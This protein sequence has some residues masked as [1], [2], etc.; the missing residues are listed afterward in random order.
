MKTINQQLDKL[1]T[2]WRLRYKDSK[3]LEKFVADGLVYKY[4]PTW[5]IPKEKENIP[6]SDVDLWVEKL[7][8]DSPVRVAFILKDKNTPDGDDVRQWL[9]L[10]NENGE[11]NRNLN[12]RIMKMLAA[13]LYGLTIDKVGYGQLDYESL[14]Q[15]WNTIP[16]AYVEAKKIAGGSNVKKKEMIKALKDDGDLL[17]HEI[18]FLDPNVLVC[19]DAD[20]TQFNYITKA[21]DKLDDQKITII[22]KHD[23]EPYFKCCLV[24]YKTLNRVVIKSYHPISRMADWIIYEKVISPYRNLL[25]DYNITLK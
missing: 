4:K 7:W 23:L 16:F 1:F 12:S 18:D 13:I 8:R 14:K 19:F 3:E 25:N 21:Y 22:K 2:E 11:I 17:L 15:K 20:D 5:G 10:E 6:G 24:Y 9:L